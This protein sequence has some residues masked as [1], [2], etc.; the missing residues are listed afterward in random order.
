[1]IKDVKSNMQKHGYPHIPVFTTEI[2]ELKYIIPH[3][4]AVY[5]N[6]HPFFAGTLPKDAANWTFQYFYDVDQ[7]P[8]MLLARDSPELVAKNQTQAKA[9]V[10]SE[11]G[12][13]TYPEDGKVKAAVPSVEN[14]QMLLETFVCQAN[15]RGL[16][17]FWFEF[18][19]E[20]W[21]ADMFNE[22]RESHWGL[23]DKE[24]KLKEIKIPDCPLQP[25]KKGDLTIPQPAPMPHRSSSFPP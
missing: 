17:Y 10:I 16:P 1:M 21:K 4:D 3:E 23:F 18:K 20:P 22:T 6:V 11:I 7:Y 5:D 19:D 2:N 25:F 8:T 12:W 13:P 14:Q 15:A 24:R 9:A